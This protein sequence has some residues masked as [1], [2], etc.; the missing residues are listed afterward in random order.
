[1]R[2]M[3]VHAFTRLQRN[4]PGY[5][6]YERIY[7]QQLQERR[8]YGWKVLDEEIVPSHAK[9]SDGCFGDTGGWVSK[10]SALGSFGRDGQFTP[11]VAV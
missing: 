4:P 11:N 7:V 10:F 5:L 6:G 2:V 3:R 1:M 8:W 9:I